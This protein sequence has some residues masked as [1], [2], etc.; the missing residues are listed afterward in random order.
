[1]CSLKKWFYIGEFSKQ[2]FVIHHQVKYIAHVKHCLTNTIFVKECL[3]NIVFNMLLINVKLVFFFNSLR[4]F[5]LK[6][7]KN[8][9][10]SL[11]NSHIK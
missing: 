7:L 6:N 4:H 9:L 11:R 10:S 3:T 2:I 8:V 5:E 1:M